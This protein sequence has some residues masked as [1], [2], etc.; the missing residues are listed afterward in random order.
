[1]QEVFLIKSGILPLLKHT[2]G[3]SNWQPCWPSRGWLVMSHQRW[4]Y[5]RGNVYH[6]CLCQVWIG[7]PTSGFDTQ[8]RHH[9]KIQNRGISSPTK[10]IYVL[11]IF[12]KQNCR[13]YVWRRL[14]PYFDSD[15]DANADV[16][17]E[18]GLNSRLVSPSPN[19]VLVHR[20]HNNQSHSELIP[21]QTPWTVWHFH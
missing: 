2:C 7:L 5:V 1:M 21:V 14:Y 9:Q 13:H 20:Y 4:M 15:V 10:R 3:E 18:H 11:Q 12:F 6:T 17:C 8:R 19:H 16:T